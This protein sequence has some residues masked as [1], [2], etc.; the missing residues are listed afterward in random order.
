MGNAALTHLRLLNRLVCWGAGCMAMRRPPPQP[1]QAGG[2]PPAAPDI[3]TYATT[4]TNAKAGM[5]GAFRDLALMHARMHACMHACTHTPTHARI[6]AR[7]HAHTLARTHTHSH[8]RIHACTHT[9][10]PRTHA[11]TFM[12]S[13]LRAPWGTE[14]ERTTQHALPPR[15]NAPMQVWTRSSSRGLCTRCPRGHPTLRVS[16]SRA[17][18]ARLRASACLPQLACLHLPT[19]ATPCTRAFALNR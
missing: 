1:P 17:H 4:F 12:R 11:H 5:D 19:T 8:A 13:P 10:T 15:A 16:A 6:Y 18:T 3:A 7:T 9:R 14:C 2:A